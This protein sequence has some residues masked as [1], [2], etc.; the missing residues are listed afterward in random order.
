MPTPSEIYQRQSNERR[1]KAENIKSAV[2]RKAVLRKRLAELAHQQSD[3]NRQISE[4][5]REI[6][7][8]G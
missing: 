8:L 4:T 6:G 7:R 3:L 1:V 5:S 2:A